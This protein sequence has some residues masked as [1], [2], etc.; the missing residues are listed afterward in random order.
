MTL[1]GTGDVTVLRHD[2]AAL[3]LLD[4]V[5]A[6]ILPEGMTGT[7]GIMTDMTATMNAAIATMI[8]VT[9]IMIAATG[10][11]NVPVTA[12]EALMRGTAISRMK[13]SAVMTIVND[14]RTS[15]R[16]SPM[17]KTGKVCSLMHAP[18]SSRG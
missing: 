1:A 10:T 12:L 11:V 2:V 16:I 17:V 3:L 14:A 13:G 8:A 15:G 9:G 6:T 4:V 7:N 18:T 5:V